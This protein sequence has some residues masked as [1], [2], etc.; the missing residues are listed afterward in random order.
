MVADGI[1][2]EIST[3]FCGQINVVTF[4]NSTLTLMLNGQS[5]TVERRVRAE[6]LEP[7]QVGRVDVSERA[8]CGAG[9]LTWKTLDHGRV[10]K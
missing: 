9:R 4:S 5:E 1:L 2:W 3:Y 8:S 10:I 6:T 7:E